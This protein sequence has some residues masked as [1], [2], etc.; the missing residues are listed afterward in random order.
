MSIFLVLRLRSISDLM[1][2]AA[3]M[4]LDNIDIPRSKLSI[5]SEIRVIQTSL[6]WLVANM[7]EYRAFLPASILATLDAE[8][9]GHAEEPEKENSFM[10]NNNTSTGSLSH[11]SLNKISPDDKKASMRSSSTKR[12]SSSRTG[13]SKFDIGLAQH[14]I[15]F[16]VF[17]FTNYKQ[18]VK[19][20]PAEEYVRVIV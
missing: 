14:K 16:A 4:Q 15:S 13:H 19:A 1:V 20:L 18:L 3:N 8:I 9:H 6:M 7:K 5:F 11:N 17:K 10:Y 2:Q 12:L